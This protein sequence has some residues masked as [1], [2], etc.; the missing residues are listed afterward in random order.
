MKRLLAY[1]GAFLLV[2]VFIFGDQLTVSAFN[3]TDLL[4][5]NI[6]SPYF[7]EEADDCGG[8]ISCAC[9]AGGVLLNG[10][11]NAEQVWGFFS[12]EGMQP[13]QIAGLMGNMMA[14][15]GLNPKRVQGT[16]TPAGDRDNVTVNGKT[17][18]GIAQWTSQGRQQHLADFAAASGVNSGDLVIQ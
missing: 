5:V 16:K 15:S 9:P 10:S 17:G 7:S 3:A 4:E 12:R 8:D 6:K 2:G 1:L 13:V 14:E 11:N 18:Y